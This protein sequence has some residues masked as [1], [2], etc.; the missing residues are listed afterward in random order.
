MKW[1]QKAYYIKLL[2]FAAAVLIA[3]TSLVVSHSMTAALAVEERNKMEV[4]AEAMHSLSNADESTDLNLV[5]KVINENNTIPVVVLDNKGNLQASRN[6]QTDADSQADS[7]QFITRRGLHMKALGHYIRLK[8][9]HGAN[10]YID[11]C[12]DDSLMLKRLTVYPYIQMGVVVLFL[13]V[14]G[15][16]LL[17]SKRAEQNRIWVGLSKETAHQLGTPISSLMAWNAILKENYPQDALIDEMGKDVQRLQRIADRFSKIGSQPNLSLHNLNEIIGNVAAYI[18]KRT[19]SKVHIIQQFD[20]PTLFVAVNELLFEWVIENL[21]KNAVDAMEG[22][23]TL[24]LR[25]MSG[26]ERA[27]IEVEDTGKG[28]RKNNLSNVF[29]PGF[30]T[31]KRGWGLGL[32]LAKRIIEEYHKGRIF[33]KHSEWGVGT[34]FRIELKQAATTPNTPAGN[35]P[36]QALHGK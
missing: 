33:V 30:T 4:W 10:D 34:T 6:I 27:I 9:G 28:I 17:A 21:C 23:G 2:L 1:T 26:K 19:S 25:V 20:T 15:L 5:L 36:E 7:V 22:K 13:V 16:A 31:K 18:Q 14:A 29:R 3:V 11:V 24:T 8:T 12:Y 35:A 32:S